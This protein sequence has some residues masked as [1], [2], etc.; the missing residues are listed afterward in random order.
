MSVLHLIP[1]A[2]LNQKYHTD[3]SPILYSYGAMEF[4]IPSLSEP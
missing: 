4:E 1:E 2:I 3:I